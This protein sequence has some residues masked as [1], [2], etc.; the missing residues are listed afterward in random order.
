MVLAMVAKTWGKAPSE[1]L[2]HAPDSLPGHLA[3]LRLAAR[4]R[5]IHED[6]E[7]NE[8]VAGNGDPFSVVPSELERLL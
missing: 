4:L 1:L 6:D 2:G 7:D 3:D 8:R 5:G